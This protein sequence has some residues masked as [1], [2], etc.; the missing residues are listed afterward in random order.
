[1]C[2]LA[3]IDHLY[4]PLPYPRHNKVHTV[5]SYV[6]TNI[7]SSDIKYTKIPSISLVEWDSAIQNIEYLQQMTNDRY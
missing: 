3:W 4:S 6:L 1:M 2:I 5:F 7:S